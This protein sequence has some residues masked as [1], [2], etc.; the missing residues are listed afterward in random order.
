[1][2]RRLLRERTG[3]S[4]L[5]H[6][7]LARRAPDAVFLWVPKTAGKSVYFALRPAGCYRLKTP[8]AVRWTFPQKGLV[9]FK[10]MDYARLVELGLVS[11]RFDA[12]AFKFGFVRNPY[13]R[14]VSLYFFLHKKSYMPPDQGFL[15][16][17]R[18]IA[19]SRLEPVGAHKLLGPGLCNPQVR[20]LERCDVDVV[21][22]FETLAADFRGITDKLGLGQ[23]ELP[24]VNATGHRHFASYFCDESRQIVEALYD[25]D[26]RS[27]GY[28]KKLPAG[29]G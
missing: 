10:H 24:W 15:D 14:A 8:E 26:F 27:F 12:S 1:M 20:W 5:R 7:A 4:Y 22:R 13:D 16:F 25:E 28:E 9:T 6:R 29:D 19:D 23:V 2:L 11:K 21:G 18:L 17:W 3:I